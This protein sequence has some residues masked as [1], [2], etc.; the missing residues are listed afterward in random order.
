VRKSAAE[1]RAEIANVR[2]E[3][4]DITQPEIARAIGISDRHLRRLDDA[5][6]T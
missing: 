5:P 1:R 6:A 3:R 2:A 4:P